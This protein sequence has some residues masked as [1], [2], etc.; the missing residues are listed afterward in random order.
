VGGKNWILSQP[1][2]NVV[3]RNTTQNRAIYLLGTSRVY[4]SLNPEIFRESFPEFQIY[5][6]AAGSSTFLHNYQTLKLLMQR[7]DSNIYLVE[8]TILKKNNSSYGPIARNEALFMPK[9]E[10][11]RYS[12][13]WRYEDWKNKLTHEIHLKSFLAVV[14]N[15][16]E[17]QMNAFSLRSDT[18]TGAK[19]SLLTLSDIQLR[20]L[21]NDS[22]FAPYLVELL[23][24]AEATHS[25]LFFFLPPVS[26]SKWE[27]EQILPGYASLP[28]ANKINYSTDFIH[29][30]QDTALLF[31]KNHHNRNGAQIIS[32]YFL[33]ELEKRKLHLKAQ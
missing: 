5:N 12:R 14:G 32:N 7:R 20:P 9:K 1:K 18:A 11:Y 3:L 25:H 27:Y 28:D 29:T 22:I 4:C 16:H 24:L 13:F 33:T 19:E 10:E 17:N 21:E 26:D 8:F 15:R 6:I 30:I 23:D 2:Y 31:D